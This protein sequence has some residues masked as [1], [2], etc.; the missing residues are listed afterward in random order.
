MTLTQEF[1]DNLK[2]QPLE[3]QALEILKI[4]DT[5]RGNEIAKNK[6]I[7]IQFEDLL[8]DLKTANTKVKDNEESLMNP[9]VFYQLRVDYVL[10][11]RKEK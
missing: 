7:L 5:A 8:Q 9:D 2:S 3:N 4:L 6:H 11:M 1:A 10:N